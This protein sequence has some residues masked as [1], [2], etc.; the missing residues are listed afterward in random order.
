MICRSRLLSGGSDLE[1]MRMAPFLA[2]RGAT[3][4]SARARRIAKFLA[5]WP[6][7]VKG[8][9]QNFS[10]KGRKRQKTAKRPHPPCVEGQSDC[11]AWVSPGR[12]ASTASS[13]SHGNH[14]SFRLVSMRV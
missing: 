4:G 6:G 5:S 7:V 8:T 2:S 10:R 14:I 12:P 9:S 13:F 11:P 1:D 3:D